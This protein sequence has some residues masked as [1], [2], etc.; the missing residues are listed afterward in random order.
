MAIRKAA[1]KAVIELDHSEKWAQAI[2][3][4]S[5][6]DLPTFFLP[7]TQC[8]FYSAAERKV[9]KGRSSRS[10]PGNWHG[11]AVVIGTEWDQGQQKESYWIRYNGRCRLA[12]PEN[13]RYA[14]MEECLTREQVVQ[15]IKSSLDALSEERKPFTFDDDRKFWCPLEERPAKRP[16]Q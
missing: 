3:Y 1:M 2:K 14:T 11:P 12:P 5:R 7:G 15:D 4:P 13:L 6:S 10:T 8:F 9:R 16:Y